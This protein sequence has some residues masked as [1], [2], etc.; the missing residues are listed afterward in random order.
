MAKREKPEFRPNIQFPLAMELRYTTY[1]RSGPKV[2]GSGRT[3]DVS[4]AELNF[5]ADAELEP[6][7]TLDISIDWP[8]PLDGGVQLQLTLSGEVVRTNG[9]FTTLRIQ[10]HEFR[11]RSLGPKV[12]PNPRRLA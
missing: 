12:V 8:V 11:T 6:G 7:L 9:T 5:T 4:S 3:M 1:G 2:S 10:R